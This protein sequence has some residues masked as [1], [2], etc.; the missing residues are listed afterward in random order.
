MKYLII[1]SIV[2]AIMASSF[3]GC[4][5]EDLG[6]LDG[7]FS[8]TAQAGPVSEMTA[9]IND[10]PWSATSYSITLTP[11]NPGQVLITGQSDNGQTINLV[12]SN[13]KQGDYLMS[14]LSKHVAY[15]SPDATGNIQ[16][17]SNGSATTGG[18]ISIDSIDTV[19]QVMTGEFN[20][21]GADSAGATAIITDG[22][23][24]NIGYI[25]ASKNVEF[26]ANINGKNWTTNSVTATVAPSTNVLTITATSANGEKMTLSFPAT[27]KARV[28]AYALTASS[29]YTASYSESGTTLV[30]DVTSTFNSPKLACAMKITSNSTTSSPRNVQGT[31]SFYATPSN[32]LTQKGDRITAGNFNVNY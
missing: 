30:P 24:V 31:F 9:K 20:F 16:Y 29:T 14:K 8:D 22:T 21:V 27:I 11:G 5:K 7:I 25:N 3:W 19:R 12:V 28:A 10:V 23:F 15:Y 17:K 32:A 1:I 26:S 13:S 2:I 4:Q 18:V 6:N